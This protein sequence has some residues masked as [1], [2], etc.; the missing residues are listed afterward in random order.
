MTVYAIPNVNVPAH[1]PYGVGDGIQTIT[2][3]PAGGTWTASCGACID[4][5]TGD[6][7]PAVAG[8]GQHTVC[9]TAGTAPCE[10]SMCIDI[11]VNDGCAI[12]GNI[13]SNPPTCYQF[14]DGSVTINVQF[15]TGNVVF[16]IED[17][18]GNQV[19][20]GNSNT[21]NN[22]T[23]GWYYFT[24]SDDF[25]CTYVDS[26][27]LQDPGQMQVTIIPTQPT[28]YGVLDGMAV[29]D[30]VL[31]YTGDYNLISYIWNPN[32]G[33]NGIGEDTLFNAGG[34]GYTL[35]VT[36]EN[37]CSEQ[38]D[39]DIPFPDSLYFTQFGADPAYCRMFG[40]QSGN[41]V[42]YGAASG[43][44][45]SPNYLWTDLQNTDSTT[46]NST[47]G[48]LNP[49]LYEIVVTDDNGCTLV[50]TVAVDS[51]NPLAEFEMT[52]PQFTANYE[53][54][55]P[56]TVTFENQSQYFANPNNPNAD[57]T[58]F[59][60]FNYDNNPPGWV[61]SHDVNEM[62]DTTYTE[63]GTYTVCLVAVNK[64]GCAD[65]T[66][67]PI[68]IYDL[69]SF[70]PLNVFTPNGDGTNDV[71]D[72]GFKS[73]AISEFYCVIVNRWGW[74]VAELTDISQ[75]WDGTDKSGS[76]CI[77]GVYFYNYRAVADNGEILEG[78]GHVH[79]IREMK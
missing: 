45:G 29:A 59:W 78:Q 43:G 61:I 67:K 12:V 64:N 52:S 16:V 36:D 32:S 1:G 13:T 10:D 41:G 69:E 79:L 53:G 39:F 30:T 3:T 20:V 4:P 44:T 6:F 46:T 35:I 19:N 54:T 24:V 72:F 55:A 77:E 48:G 31:N 73:E 63:G 62:F 9:Y 75:N 7:D 76:D 49:G 8:I 11:Y 56:V 18:L 66:C 71:F 74:T 33:S 51:L 22:L 40:Y 2:G 37:G 68:I 47:W 23:E 34:T 70:T 14:N 15:T 17:T 57:T 58:F 65:T 38:I 27:Y 5:N 42:V 25:P 28:C 21:A 26:V 50:D 60:H